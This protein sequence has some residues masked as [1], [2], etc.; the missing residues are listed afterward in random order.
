MIVKIGELGKEK[1]ESLAGRVRLTGR[2]PKV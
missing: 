1:A 2:E